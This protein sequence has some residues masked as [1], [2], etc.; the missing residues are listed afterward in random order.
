LAEA[1]ASRRVIELWAGHAEVEEHAVDAIEAGL[2]SDGRQVPEVALAQDGR[3][4]GA[5]KPG[6]RHVQRCS[7]AVDT[8]QAPAGP[9]SLQDQ[10]RVATEADRAVDNDRTGPGL[11]EIY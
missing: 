6:R 3:R 1:E 7:V 10:T 8:K 2:G 9:D 11:Q 4:A 5:G